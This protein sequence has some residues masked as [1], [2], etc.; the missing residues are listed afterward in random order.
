MDP[1]PVGTPLTDAL[2]GHWYL[3]GVALDSLLSVYYHAEMYRLF[4]SPERVKRFGPIRLTYLA[5]GL[6]LFLITEL[7][8]EVYR[9]YIYQNSIND[10]GLADVIGNLF[11]TM[12]IIFFELGI[13][14]ATKRQGYRIIGLVTV[15]VAIYEVLQA[16]L[17]KGVLDIKDVVSTF[18]AGLISVVLLALIWRFVS[19]PL[20]EAE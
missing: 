7:G 9:P 13:L 20:E 16:I 12:T 10:Y 4:F 1:P 18:V 3:R 8:R 17:P 6:V 11:G 5:I 2:C 14:H 19:D 15:G